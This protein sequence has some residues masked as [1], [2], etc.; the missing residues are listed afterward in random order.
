MNKKLSPE[1]AFY[2]NLTL[3]LIKTLSNV[4]RVCN[5][6]L[7]RRQ[8]L[9][10]CQ[11]VNWEQRHCVYLPEDMKKFY[12]STDGFV[13]NWSYQ[14]APN[15][16]RRVG[17]IHFPHLLQ[18][19]L[20]RENIETTHSSSNAA[21]LASSNS[22]V[23]GPSSQSQSLS[24]AASTGKDKW[25]NA[26]PI[27]TP[28]SKIFEIN[29]VNEVAKVCMLYESTSSN[30]P[31]FYLLELSTLS[32]Q[33]L[34]DTFSEYLR[35][36]IAHLGLPY[37]ELC[38]S[39]C[40]L[41]SWTEQLFLLLAPHLLEEHES[42]RGRVLNPACEHPYNIIDPNIFR[43]KPKSVAKTAPNTKQSHK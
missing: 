28:K 20:L 12:L 22:D 9:N 13:L 10:A 36:A 23:L 7:E 30:N 39:S 15:D 26:T 35:M 43:G 11:V 42:R 25:G 14:Y 5:V 38:F 31:K 3:G 1:D 37:W 6:T 27:I 4:P 40:G 17:H 29:N 2:E 24:A 21:S 18:V 41:P 33:F 19:T 32:W 34:A 16:I 8:P